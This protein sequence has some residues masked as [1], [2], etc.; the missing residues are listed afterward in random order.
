MHPGL[1]A[2]RRIVNEVIKESLS[3]EA[4]QICYNDTSQ[5]AE[6]FRMTVS[7]VMKESL[8]NLTQ[9][10]RTCKDDTS[11]AAE[12]CGKAFKDSEAS[13][14]CQVQTAANTGLIL[15]LFFTMLGLQVV[16]I[17]GTVFRGRSC[18]WHWCSRCIY[19]SRYYRI[20]ADNREQGA[21][22]GQGAGS[23]EQEAVLMESTS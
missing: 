12:T 23:R 9:A 17:V 13:Q 7:D 18:S 21:V 3:H 19:C 14:Q 15:L 11:Q 5:A 6:T 20:R 8:E 22:S 4:V 1:D 10:V 2:V 16:T